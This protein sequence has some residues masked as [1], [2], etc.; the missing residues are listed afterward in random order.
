MTA[1]ADKA[2]KQKTGA[3][4]LRTIIEETL[5]DI[6]FEIPSQEAISKCVITADVI[7]GTSTPRL[8]MRNGRERSYDRDGHDK[9]DLEESA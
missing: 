7:T 3:R 4:G 9:D 5:L 1:A 6:M 2:L 8:V